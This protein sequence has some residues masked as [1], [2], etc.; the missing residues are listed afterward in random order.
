MRAEP[1][2]RGCQLTEWRQ[3][4]ARGAALVVFL[5]AMASCR[6]APSPAPLRLPPLGPGDTI[7]LAVQGSA[8]QAPV[9]TARSPLIAVAFVASDARG[10]RVYLSTSADNG[11]TFTP[12]SPVPDDGPSGRYEDL[13]AI[14]QPGAQAEDGEPYVKVEWRRGDGQTASRLIQ[15]WP[16]GAALAKPAAPDV[17][18]GTAVASCEDDGEVLLVAGFRG[19]GPVSVN[20]ALQDQRCAAGEATAIVD[21]RNWVHAAWVGGRDAA[22]HRVFYTASP[23][24]D[25]FGG[26]HPLLDAGQT[27]SHVRITTDPND[28]IVAVWDAEDGATRQVV[29][30]Q[31]LPAHH[32]P[33]TLLPVTHLSAGAGGVEPSIAAIDGGVIVGWRVPSTGGVALR[34]VGLDAICDATAIAAPLAPQVPVAPR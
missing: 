29:L 3:K 4:T 31:I 21:A 30:R 25:W 23:D 26:A 7:Q 13:A 32:G 33:P 6:Q 9:V 14:L 11:A 20:H 2:R 18:R 24:R 17:P 16:R 28:T 34:R 19:T 15:P 12:P 5:G 22:A 8:A 27:P 10:A 1:A